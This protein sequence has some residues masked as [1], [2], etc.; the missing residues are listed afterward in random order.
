MAPFILAFSVSIHAAV[1]AATTAL[2]KLLQAELFQSTRPCGPRHVDLVRASREFGFNPRGR[3]GRDA[4]WVVVETKQ[5]PVSIHAAVRAATPAA[6]RTFQP[7]TRFNPRGR[8]GR[9]V[10]RG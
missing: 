8:A 3:A 5:E 7:T 4:P 2:N 6:G 10:V 9:D 1:R